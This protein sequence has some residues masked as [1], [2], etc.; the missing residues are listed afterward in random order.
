M[1]Y[2]LGAPRADPA[3]EA[4]VWIGSAGHAAAEPEDA[5]ELYAFAAER[6]V[7]EGRTRHHVLVPA[8]DARLVDA[9]FRLCFGQQQAHGVRE[10]P[11]EI[12]ADVPDGYEIRPPHLADL[13]AL[14]DLD[15][16]LPGHQARSP[17]F[18]GVRR[19]DRD[20]SRAEWESTLAEGVERILIGYHGDLPVA[21]WS[22]VPIALSRH[23][24]G[25]MSVERAAYLAFAATLPEIR[26]SGIGVALTYAC[27][28]AAAEEGYG[29]MVTDWR[30][31]NLLASRFW[32]RRGFRPFFLRLYRSIP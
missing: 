26:G 2:V 9:W 19:D 32:P 22:V 25:L 30:V 7:E 1:G 23:Y 17:V 24:H 5:R 4:N 14:I 20:E 8:T 16:A 12:A 27:F 28:R 15:L 13:E 18:S 6:W 29:A 21:C 31:T 3:S 11:A 10:L